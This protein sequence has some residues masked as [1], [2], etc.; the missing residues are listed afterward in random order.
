MTICVE[1][2][3]SHI[4]ERKFGELM[5]TIRPRYK[6][7]LEERVKNY[8]ITD[9]NLASLA[10]CYFNANLKAKDVFERLTEVSST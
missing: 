5:T 8:I 4:G 9:K 3:K 2:K 1:A 10:K 7:K 6:P